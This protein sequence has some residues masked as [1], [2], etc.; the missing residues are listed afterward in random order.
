[1]IYWQAAEEKA[2]KESAR[3]DRPVV[4]SE[5]Q[6]PAASPEAEAESG[7]CVVGG[8]CVRVCVVGRGCVCVIGCVCEYVYVCY[9]V[10]LYECA[11]MIMSSGVWMQV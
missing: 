6:T 1:M 5:P 10:S 2:A 3:G 7:V 11:S 4:I 9:H 8:G